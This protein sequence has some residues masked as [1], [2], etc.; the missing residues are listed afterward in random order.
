M[1]SRSNTATLFVGTF[2]S[3]FLF[4]FGAGTL[5]LMFAPVFADV[6]TAKV[7]YQPQLPLSEDRTEPFLDIDSI[8]AKQL[9]PALSTPENVESGNWIRIPSIG[10][11]VPLALSPTIDDKDVIKTLDLG[12]ALYPN[13]IS[14]GR[15]GN[16]FIAAHSTGEPWKGKY[17]FAFLKVN[18]IQP[19]NFIHLDY[20]GT[21]YTYRVVQKDIVKPTPD[22]RVIS[23]RPMPTVTLMACWPL[24]STD[25]R[26]LIRGELAHITKLTPEPF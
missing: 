1:K 5:L 18:D 8:P 20:N 19:D 21:R 13:G 26:M 23:D 4:I 12:A 6:L 22:F 16:T 14:P 2:V 15:L 24:W 3:A 10:V 11:N 7:I 9:Y 17:R 25:K